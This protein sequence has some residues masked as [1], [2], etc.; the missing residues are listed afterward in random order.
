MIELGHRYARFYMNQGRIETDG[1]AYEIET[2]WADFQLRHL[3]WVQEADILYLFHADVP[4]HR[5]SRFGHTD[6]RIDGVN[7]QD[8]PFLTENL[9]TTRLVTA[10]AVSGT[11]VTLSASGGDV[12]EPSHVGAL[13]RLSEPEPDA[14]QPWESSR[15]FN[16]GDQV[17]FDGRIY[18]VEQQDSLT[19]SVPPIHR[20]GLAWD[21]KGLASVQWR[22]LHDGSGVVRIDSYVD[23]RTVRGTVLSRLPDSVVDGSTSRWAEGAWSERR[24]YPSA[25]TFADQRL[26]TAAS[27]TQPMTFWGSVAAGNYERFEDGI[28]ED[29]SF[30]YTLASRQVN[31]IRW[32]INA[33]ILLLGSC[34]VIWLATGPDFEAPLSPVGV[35][36]RPATEEGAA[37]VL[38]VV[39]GNAVLYLSQTQRRLLELTFDGGQVNYAARDLTI[40]ADHIA[41]PEADQA[42]G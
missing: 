42:G 32:L 27:K 34:D 15:P 5:L 8:G 16:P 13:F 6:W 7:P 14:I 25:A 9:D 1:A 30:S 37:P 41:I 36:A 4:P 31:I 28:E 24:G 20:E 11:Q 29:Q 18:E 17:R 40:L 12:W 35:R 21:G 19:G 39:I 33:P 2:P 10:S 38:P 22:Y 3:T 23:P 26:I